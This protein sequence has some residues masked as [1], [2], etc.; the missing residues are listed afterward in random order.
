MQLFLRAGH[1]VTLS[2]LS[3]PVRLRGRPC[4]DDCLAVGSLVA[5]YDSWQQSTKPL[6]YSFC[7]NC[8]AEFIRR[9]LMESG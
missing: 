8:L 3:D 1:N 9:Y 5:E 7:S 6:Y 4:C 2:R